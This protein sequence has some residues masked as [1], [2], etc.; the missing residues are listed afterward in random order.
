ME[1]SSFRE[2]T[3]TR[4][5]CV[6]QVACIQHLAQALHAGAGDVALDDDAL[7]EVQLQA[8]IAVRGLR[9]RRRPDDHDVVVC[10]RGGST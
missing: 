8:A 6:V 5:Q 10:G 2:R 9:A 4:G 3:V 1:C 7:T